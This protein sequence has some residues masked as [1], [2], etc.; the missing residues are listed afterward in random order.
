MTNRLTN[1]IKNTIKKRPQTAP[2][3]KLL[4]NDFLPVSRESI[5]NFP[6]GGSL[7]RPAQPSQ[8]SR[9]RACSDEKHFAFPHPYIGADPRQHLSA[10]TTLML[11]ALG[12]LPSISPAIN[13]GSSRYPSES[14]EPAAD[15][16]RQLP[17]QIPQKVTPFITFA[18][19]PIFSKN[20]DL[21]LTP[22]LVRKI[23]ASLS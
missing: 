11:R 10:P 7:L 14:A 18:S 17:I 13:T 2:P 22:E 20:H 16:P 5:L 1:R 19:A 23:G 4:G 21:S 8:T 6:A 9:L 12:T 3:A 15:L